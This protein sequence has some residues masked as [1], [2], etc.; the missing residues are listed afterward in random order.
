MANVKFRGKE[1]LVEGEFPSIGDQAAPF[2]LC[3][4]DLTDITL[5]AYHGQKLVLNIFP[6]VDTAVCA[7]T[8]KAFN[9]HAAQLD[10]VKVLCISADLPFASARFCGAE[11]IKD[12]TMVSAFRSPE[13]MRDYGVAIAQG[14]LRNLAA[15]A[16]ICI[17]EQ[18]KVIYS[19]LVDEIIHEPNYQAALDS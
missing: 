19:E 4:A 16:V 2:A 1:V 10:G 15:R 12:V 18:G 17:N 3:G 11:G 8:V 5:A 14:P 6:S 9:Q 13:F 7:L